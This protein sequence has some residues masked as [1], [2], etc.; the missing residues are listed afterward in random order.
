VIITIIEALE[1][2]ES[3]EKADGREGTD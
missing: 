1:T 2:T 3:K